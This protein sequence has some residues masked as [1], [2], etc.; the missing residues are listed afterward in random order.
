MAPYFCSV[1]RRINGSI[2]KYVPIDATKKASKKTKQVVNFIFS[3]ALRLY[4][5]AGVFMSRSLMS[6]KIA[7]SLAFA[8]TSTVISMD[9]QA[10]GRSLTSI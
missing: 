10:P 9:S 8:S 2:L 1:S 6:L 3:M 5:A 4:S 7:N